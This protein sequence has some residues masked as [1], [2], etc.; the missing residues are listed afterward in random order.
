MSSYFAQNESNQYVRSIALTQQ[1]SGGENGRALSFSVA[2]VAML[3]SFKD[4]VNHQLHSPRICL[5]AMRRFKGTQVRLLKVCFC[6]SGIH[7]FSSQEKVSFPTEDTSPI[8][9]G[10]FEVI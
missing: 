10:D 7:E 3:T 1:Q 6:C 5:Y 2:V 8:H 9:A 4:N